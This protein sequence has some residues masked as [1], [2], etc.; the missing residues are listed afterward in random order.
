MLGDRDRYR[1]EILELR[2][3]VRDEWRS[4]SAELATVLAE[5]LGD[6]SPTAPVTSEVP[7]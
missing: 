4:A 2:A 3:D 6:R 7:R 1:S 5:A